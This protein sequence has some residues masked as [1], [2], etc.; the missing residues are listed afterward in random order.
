MFLRHFIEYALLKGSGGT[1]PP[2][3]LYWVRGEAPWQKMVLGH[4]KGQNES[5]RHELNTFSCI[6]LKRPLQDRLLLNVGQAYCRM[7]QG[8]CNTFNLH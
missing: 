5:S 7:L 6:F 3:P 2:P 1:P 4:F 8:V